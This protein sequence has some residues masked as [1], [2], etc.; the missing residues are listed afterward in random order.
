MESLLKLL[1]CF[2]KHLNMLFIIISEAAQSHA[3][4]IFKSCNNNRLNMLT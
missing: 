2:F 4:R 3:E 1:S